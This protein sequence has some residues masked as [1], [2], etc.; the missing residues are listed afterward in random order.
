MPRTLKQR[1]AD[2]HEADMA[3][4]IDGK[5]QKGSGN[6]WHAQGDLK[7]GEHL[8]AYPITGEGKATLGK[9][10]TITREM[11]GKLVEQTFSQNPAL[12]LRWYR[13]ESLRQVDIDLAVTSVSLFSLILRDARKWQAI[14][15]EFFPADAGRPGIADLEEVLQ[16][17]RA[18]REALAHPV[19]YVR[20]PVEV[21][22]DCCR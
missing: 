1:M 12:F 16:I 8:V 5:V 6:Q 17:L 14:E 7:N 11:W 4:L 22:C 3:D 10:H 9:G 15:D 21:G 18:G 2:A 13:D 20:V 19:Q